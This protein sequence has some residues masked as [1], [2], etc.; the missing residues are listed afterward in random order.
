MDT[1]QKLTHTRRRWI[2]ALI[3]LSTL[4]PQAGAQAPVP[5]IVCAGF[6]STAEFEG[7]DRPFELPYGQEALIRT[8]S[9][10]NKRTIV[11]LTAGGNV[12]MTGWLDSVPP[13]PP[14]ADHASAQWRRTFDDPFNGAALNRCWKHAYVGD[15]HTLEANGEE[16]WYASPGD[17]TGYDPFRLHDGVLFMSA[18]PTPATVRLPRPYPYLSGMIMSDGCFAQKYGYFEIRAKVPGGKGL[19]P[20][21][22]LLPVSHKWPPEID[23][24]EMFG[25]PNSRREGGLGWVH[26]G[27]VGGGD[28]AFNAWH[29][30]AID[31]YSAFHRY[32]LLWG[33]E[34]MAIYLDGKLLASQSTPEHFHVP[35]YLIANLAVGGRWPESPDASTRFPASFEIDEIQ[36]WQYRPW[37]DLK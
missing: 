9:S 21:F 22:W 16:E 19:W 18:I 5:V 32:G 12:A 20:A 14:L 27:T 33:P 4:M 30:T 23:V 11:A 26:T 7:M 3:F 28:S 29:Q 13:P 8:L 24:F 25:A 2:S 34:Y 37:S 10:L 17:G 36:A 1:L 35:M 31:Q 15:V 6:N